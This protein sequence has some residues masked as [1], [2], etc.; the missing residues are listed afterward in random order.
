VKRL[1]G[2]ALLLMLAVQPAAAPAARPPRVV[3]L[4]AT[5]LTPLAVQDFEAAMQ[6]LGWVQGRNI[7]IDFR[8]ADGEYARLP[9]LVEEVLRLN[10]QVVVTAQTPTTRAIR[11]VTDAM[12]IVMVGH[13]DPVRYGVV[14]NLARPEGNTTGTA[15]LVNEVG[16]KVLE[17]LKEAVPSATRVAF[18]VNPDNPGARP[19]LEAAREAAPRLGFTIRP[20]EIASA[21]DLHRELAALPRD[22]VDAMWLGPEAFLLT[23]RDEILGFALARRLPAVGASPAFAASGALLSYAPHYPSMVRTSA[24]YVD[25]ILKGAKPH[26]LPIEQPARFE[27]II[28]AKT[29]KLLGIAVP[30]ALLLRAD[31][32]IE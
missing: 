16:V 32:V 2:S 14:K 15:F 11:K 20:V 7:V 9:A 28:N 26:D 18:F 25:K 31:R 3:F 8:S 10:P 29:A 5:A 21:S 23:N 24:A 17:L 19:L 22:G 1:L 12:P 30:P 6:E 4:S 13:G 27:L